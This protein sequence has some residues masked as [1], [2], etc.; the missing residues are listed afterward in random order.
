MLSEASVYG[1]IVVSALIIVTRG[2]SDASWDVFWKVLGTVIVFYIAHAF[3]S[4]VS[5]LG[6]DIDGDKSIGRLLLYGLR[7]ASGLLLAAL[8]PLTVLLLGATDVISDDAAI[9]IVL[10]LDVAILGVLGFAAV[11]RM[12]RNPRS[13][14]L[15]GA[16]TALLGI[17]IMV[18]KVLIH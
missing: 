8:I 9:W 5:H 18:M 6:V 16:L 17:A 11:A 15:G 12:T 13:R 4:V 7:H 1:V 10:W 2:S 14:A 3:A